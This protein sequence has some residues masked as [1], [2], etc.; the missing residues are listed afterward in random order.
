MSYELQ[1]SKVALRNRIRAA[2]KTISPG[3]R[4]AASAQ[5][6]DRLQVQPIWKNAQAVLCFAPLPD[7]LDLWP[8]LVEALAEDK[9]IALPRFESRTQTYGAARLEHLH[10]DIRTGQFSIREPGEHC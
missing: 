9:T 2:L 4:A 8:L 3:A 1:A 5:A 7:E 10:A 6:C